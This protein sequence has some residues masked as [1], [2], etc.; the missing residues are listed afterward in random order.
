MTQ[1]KGGAAR[2]AY[3]AAGVDVAAG[4]HAVELLRARIAGAGA[5]GID[6]LGGLGGFGAALELPDGIRRPVLVCATDGVGTK[7]EIAR[8]TGRLDTIGQD[9]VAMCV[10]D[11]VCHGAQPWFFLDYL[12]VGRLVP[13]RVAALVGGIADGCAIAGCALVGGETA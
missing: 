2:V 13:D 4:D 10:D 6:L 7:T 1:G 3:A 9:L 8:R 12:A 11:L 5:A